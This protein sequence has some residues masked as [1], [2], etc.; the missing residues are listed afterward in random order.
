[1]SQRIKLKK[2][3]S[4]P[5]I[6]DP[7]QFESGLNIIMG[8]KS[9]DSKKT[10]G[11]G[12][13]I[14]IE[15]LN[16]CLL[17]K[18]SESRVSLIPES[19]VDKTSKIMLDLL[20][21]QDNITIVRSLSHL[22]EITIFKDGEEIIFDSIDNAT[23]Y[24]G[25]LYFKNYSANIPRISFRNMLAPVIRDE[26]SEFKDIIQCFDTK[27][28]IPLDYKPHLFFLHL[29][30]ELY[31]EIKRILKE[32]ENKRTYLNE[33]KKILIV[34]PSDAKAQLNELQ[35]EVTKINASIESL[36]NN[37]SFD[38]IQNDLVKIEFELSKLRKVQQA[39]KY[40]IKQIE[41][42]PQPENISK[43]DISIL[44]NQ[45]KAGL[46]DMVEKS[47]IELEGF[48][49]KINSFR[50]S[51]VNKRLEDL[52]QKLS[53]ISAKV[54]VFDGQYAEKISLLD[55]GSLLKDLKSSINIFNSKNSELSN[56]RSLIDRYD[57]AEKDKKSLLKIKAEKVAELD[58]DILDKKNIID[59]FENTI[60]AIHEIIMG[61]RKSH[62]EIKTIDKASAKEFIYFDLRI[63]DD[64][65][66]SIE[67]MKVF[68]YDISLMTNAGTS[69]HH[70]KFL[71]HD[72]IFDS[73][74]DSLEKSLNFLYEAANNNPEE[75]Q[76]IITLNTDKVELL[77]SKGLLN[78][79]IN[80]YK[81]ASYTKS[82][83]FLRKQYS[84][85]KKGN[86]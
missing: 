13:S 86:K 41:S 7:I 53:D 60:L 62:F 56:L 67:R 6:F 1:M 47:L 9:T 16:F 8:D 51:L 72:N 71:V 31:I 69:I 66:H 27:K 12:K 55:N 81:R 58:E 80:N 29:N 36:K 11:V 75:F 40:E 42:L 39:I 3:Y 52:K 10:N 24:L 74:D 4:E 28:R 2:L 17:K 83:R 25:A 46:G 49:E 43:N 59:S 64:G 5:E 21:N 32:L 33:T 26:R 38:A 70:P 57:T 18:F 61:N 50:N 44:Y 78:F 37:E 34:K 85:V 77:E 30:I 84:E 76:Y 45:F 68:I 23:E 35:S 22:E 48:K 19:T 14:C 20:I 73:D 15:F 54:K 82:N 63:D 79:D 65:G